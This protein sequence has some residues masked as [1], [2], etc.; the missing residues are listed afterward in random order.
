MVRTGDIR[1]VARL[2]EG[3]TTAGHV[4]EDA[5]LARSR[6]SH[7]SIQLEVPRPDQPAAPLRDAGLAT[8]IPRRARGNPGHGPELQTARPRTRGAHSPADHTRPARIERWG[9]PKPAE[10]AARGGREGIAQAT[11]AVISLPVK[12]VRS[13]VKAIARAAKTVTH[14][15]DNILDDVVRRAPGRADE[16]RAVRGARQSDSLSST[17]HPWSDASASRSS[18][19]STG[20]TGADIRRRLMERSAERKAL[21]ERDADRSREESRRIR[22]EIEQ[23]SRERTQMFR[24]AHKRYRSEQATI[25]RSLASTA[26]TRALMRPAGDTDTLLR[27]AQFFELRANSYSA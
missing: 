12:L 25:H 8:R 9:G 16:T 26:T 10:V 21:R 22:A 19:S 4:L 23:L 7:G 1:I 11:R 17:W 6:T 20:E 15:A 27:R 2:A 14:S 5:A 13:A 24:D 18:S 3:S